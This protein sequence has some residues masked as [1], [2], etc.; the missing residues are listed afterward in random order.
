MAPS[1]IK[2]KVAG[3]YLKM[4]EQ[5]WVKQAGWSCRLEFFHHSWTEE[6]RMLECQSD[7]SVLLQ[8]TNYVFQ[9]SGLHLMAFCTQ[10]SLE[11]L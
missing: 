5:Y 4:F 3:S 7:K 10:Y 1:V 6:Q 9:H 11:F 8:G 2:C